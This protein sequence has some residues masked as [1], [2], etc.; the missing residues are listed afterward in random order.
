MKLLTFPFLHS[1]VWTRITKSTP[2]LYYL[3][4][5]YKK[6][7]WPPIFIY[8]LT[9]YLYQYVLVCMYIYF[10]TLGYVN[11]GC[12]PIPHYLFSCPNVLSSGSWEIF[13]V[14]SSVPLTSSYFLSTSLLSGT[15]G[16]SR[17]IFHFLCPALKS[18][19]FPRSSGFFH[20][21]MV[22]RSQNQGAGSACCYGHVTAS[23]PPPQTELGHR[24]MH[25]GPCTHTYTIISE[26]LSIFN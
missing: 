18:A 24:C 1:T 25:N 22:F 8:S 7:L 12:N 2:H 9:A 17:F 26:Y 3:E 6:D 5:C 14:V 19:I 10:Y 4:Y 15:T 20:Y 11:L 16:C 13:W 21:I 23:S